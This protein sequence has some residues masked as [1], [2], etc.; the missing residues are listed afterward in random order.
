M[1]FGEA[2]APRFRRGPFTLLELL[3]VIA[4]IAILAAILLP[5]LAAAKESQR[6]V[7]CKLIVGGYGK[8]LQLYT[9]DY[10]E[11]LPSITAVGIPHAFD[12]R[13]FWELLRD[14]Y[15]I[16]TPDYYIDNFLPPT[17]STAGF[18][19]PTAVLCQA[20]QLSYLAALSTLE[21][22]KLYQGRMSRGGAYQVA[23]FSQDLNESLYP[24]HLSR[25]EAPDAYFFMEDAGFND[26]TDDREYPYW[27]CEQLLDGHYFWAHGCY[28]NVGF[29]DGH[30]DG[31]PR[32]RRDYS[33]AAT[34]DRML[35][36][37]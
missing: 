14:Y 5:T 25:I 36:P 23:L 11:C 28:Y 6:R 15:S 10:K 17:A 19:I 20:A 18:R 3:V 12:F 1:S 27:R 37:E 26:R 7:Q 21:T 29:L 4:V 32:K 2:T 31:F 30:V 34:L 24:R 35:R 9:A 8:A 22:Q 13:Y 33:T 16:D